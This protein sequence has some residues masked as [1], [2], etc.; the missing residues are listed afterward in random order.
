MFPGSFAATA[1]DRPAVIMASTGA[2]QTYADLDAEA[3]RLSQLFRAAGLQAGDHVAFCLENHPRFL[4]IMWG[5][6]YAGLYYTALSS[7]LTT[8]EMAYIVAD[9]G[10][11]AFIT[12]DYKRSQ[13]AELV[14]KMPG[15]RVR[16]MVDAVIDG[17][18]SFEEAVAAQPSEPL[19][20][21][22]EGQDMLYSS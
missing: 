5:A 18:E 4:S 14:D 16:L 7:R 13:A 17:Y 1:P 21:R 12:S 19:P 3:N 20:D 8:E 10:A 6:H 2:I 9:C 15:V 22:V 11:Q